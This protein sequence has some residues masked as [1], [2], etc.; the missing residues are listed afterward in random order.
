[1]ARCLSRAGL[2][3]SDSAESGSLEAGPVPVGYSAQEQKADQH[4]P[5]PR[6]AQRPE[7]QA[8]SKRHSVPF[9]QD[10]TTAQ[11]PGRSKQPIAAATFFCKGKFSKAGTPSVCDTRRRTLVPGHFLFSLDDRKS[12]SVFPRHYISFICALVPNAQRRM[13]T[14]KTAIP[15]PSTAGPFHSSA[16]IRGL[17]V[18]RS[19]KSAHQLAHV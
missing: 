17:G 18:K 14:D 1:M 6:R 4:H 5:A 8:R 3:E 12:D 2:A 11:T 10:T 15:P 19:W 9:A 16:P 13:E 7:R